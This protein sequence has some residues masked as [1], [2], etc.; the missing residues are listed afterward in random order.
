MEMNATR[1]Q[2]PGP[3]YETRKAL[4]TDA[5]TGETIYLVRKQRILPGGYIETEH[6]VTR[7][8]RK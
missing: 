3:W 4:G 8:E 6:R 1:K 7:W 2:K 5:Q